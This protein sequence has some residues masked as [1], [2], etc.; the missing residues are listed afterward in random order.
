MS[1]IKRAL[2][3]LNRYPDGASFYLRNAIAKK[4]GLSSEN[5]VLGNGSDEVIVLA[6]RAFVCPGDEVII[7]RPTF[8][9]YEI[10]ASVEGVKV[11]TVPQRDFRYDL[12]AI[13]RAITG[14]TKLIFIANP[15]NPTGT[16][17]TK[18]DVTA[19]LKKLTPRTIVF[20]DEAY[21]EFARQYP[22]YPDTL[23]YIRTRNVIVSRTF[24]KI[25]SLAGLRIGYAMGCRELISAMEK[26][27]EPFNI[28]S[29]A[30]AGALAAL[31]DKQFVAK[32]LKIVN[33][34][35]KFLYKNIQSLGF[36][37]IP[38]V[39]NFI[40]VHVGDSGAVYQRLLRKGVIVREMTSWGLKGFI[41][42][43]IGTRQENAKFINA[44]KSAR[45]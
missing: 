10:A 45:D 20:F 36:K 30:Q 16:Y 15:D 12:Q 31:S 41:R 26:V 3:D 32:S 38:S 7:S 43:T 35:R 39:T 9:V 29:L 8:A 25:Y 18:K 17:V 2:K 13:S 23:P 37:Y 44:L 1:A 40:L 24:S 14:K 42:V 19:F 28:N 21:Y 6:I 33:E 22:D 34:G 11:I 27:R 5:I 4:F